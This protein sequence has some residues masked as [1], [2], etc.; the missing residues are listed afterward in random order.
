M[1]GPCIFYWMMRARGVGDW[2]A[3]HLLLDGE[4]ASDALARPRCHVGLLTPPGRRRSKIV[5]AGNKR[6]GDWL[7][8]CAQAHSRSMVQFGLPSRYFG[9]LSHNRFAPV[10][11]D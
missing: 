5:A 9:P 4:G 11:G 2:Q 1:S 3:P 7:A 6:R 10:P 8:S